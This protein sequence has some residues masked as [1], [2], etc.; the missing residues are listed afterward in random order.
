MTIVQPVSFHLDRKRLRKFA[1]GLPKKADVDFDSADNTMQ[2]NAWN[3][4]EFVGRNS[5]RMFVEKL[6]E[7]CQAVEGSLGEFA[8]KKVRPRL[9]AAIST[10]VRAC[11]L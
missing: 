4:I 10:I 9:Q 1:K 11:C 8:P 3:S 7:H 2:F 5:R 6:G